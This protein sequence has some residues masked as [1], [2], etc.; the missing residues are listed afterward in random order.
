MAYKQ[1][2][3]VMKGSRVKLCMTLTKVSTI[4]AKQRVAHHVKQDTTECGWCG[5]A[6][7][8]GR[9]SDSATDFRDGTFSLSRFGRGY[10]SRVTHGANRLISLEDRTTKTKNSWSDIQASP[11]HP[12]HK[13]LG[14][15]KLWIP[16]DACQARMRNKHLAS[17]VKSME[18]GMMLTGT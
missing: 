10:L 11:R 15:Q 13:Y 17:D 7:K 3:Y 4:A 9:L 8:V 1:R 14:H 16:G 5:Q 12:S 6:G 2:R 18:R